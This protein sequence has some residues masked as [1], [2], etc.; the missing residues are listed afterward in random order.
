MKGLWYKILLILFLVIGGISLST[1]N[2]VLSNNNP[3]SIRFLDDENEMLILN[4]INERAIICEGRN[5]LRNNVIQR[6]L[7]EKV[8]E[9]DLLVLR[10]ADL[11]CNDFLKGVVKAVKIK[12]IVVPD[13]KILS[14]ATKDFLKRSDVELASFKEGLNYNIGNLDIRGE[15]VEGLKNEGILFIEVDNI[16]VGLLSRGAFNK[17][18]KQ[19]ESV[20]S[21]V[22]VLNLRGNSDF[23]KSEFKDMIKTL[24]PIAVIGNQKNVAY[25]NSESRKRGVK[26]YSLRG[27]GDL[28]LQRVMGETKEFVIN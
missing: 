13:T 16:K 23:E 6:I 3:N 28:S 4:T 1:N 24:S 25:Y 5:A 21:K 7:D 22:D 20:N 10:T 27:Y 11:E 17:A 19:C 12:K 26:Y 14:E 9:V 18:Q 8:E 2:L 15:G